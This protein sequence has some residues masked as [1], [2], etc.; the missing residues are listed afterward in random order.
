MRSHELPGEDIGDTDT[1]RVRF[2][3]NSLEKHVYD[4]QL[5]SSDV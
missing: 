2:G 3:G 5:L 1:E 4:W